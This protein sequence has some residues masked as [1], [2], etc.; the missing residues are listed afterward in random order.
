MFWLACCGRSAT[1]LG[2]FLLLGLAVVIAGRRAATREYHNELSA[3][4]LGG[5]L[6]KIGKAIFRKPLN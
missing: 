5:Q 1:P 2:Q 3:K 4:P 6:K